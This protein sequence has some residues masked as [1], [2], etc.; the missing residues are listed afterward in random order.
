MSN[1]NIELEQ[2]P[3]I[4]QTQ[5]LIEGSKWLLKLWLMSNEI[6]D[7]CNVS[8]VRRDGS[9]ALTG[10]WDAGTHEIRAQTFYSDIATGTAP[11]TVV[12]ST[13]V[14]NFNA[15]K[16]DGYDF[17]QEVKTTSSPFFTKLGINTTTPSSYTLNVNGTTYSTGFIGAYLKPVADSTTALQLQKANGT[18]IMIIDTTN[19]KIGIGTNP[20]YPLDLYTPGGQVVGTCYAITRYNQNHSSYRG[21]GFG[22]DTSGQIGLIYSD[23]A[24]VA[25]Q[26]AFWTY[27]GTAWGERVRFN[28]TGVGI[29]VTAPSARLH[30][31]A[32]TA[33]ANTAPLKFTSGTSLTTAT[34]GAVEFTTDDL[35]FTITTGAARKGFILNDGTNLTAGR[36]PFATTNGRLTDDADITFSG[37][38]LTLNKLVLTSLTSMGGTAPVADGTYTVG[39]GA[40]QNGTITI[41][42][43]II[44]A[45]QEASS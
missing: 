23:T 33:T 26:I 34:A 7:I 44:T 5:E 28:T 25:S 41:K 3:V 12:S 16:A 29:G 39:I 1:V 38:T 36:V 43:G 9:E 31:A 11:M 20:T 27:S 22:Y 10:D 15:D 13:V 32:G 8:Y 19:S 24:S 35:Y 17:D 14:T 21:L 45:V 6:K 2:P 18:A 40:V 30:L 37:D 4:G 42:S